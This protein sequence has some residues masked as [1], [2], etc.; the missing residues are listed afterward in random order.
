MNIQV[1]R[2]ALMIISGAAAVFTIGFWIKYRRTKKIKPI[3]KCS[4]VEKHNEAINDAADD[5][6]ALINAKKD[7]LERILPKEWMKIGQIKELFVYPLKSGRGRPLKDSIFTDYG[8]SVTNNGHFPLRD[9]MFLVYKEETGEFKTGRNYPTLVLVTLSAVD[10]TQVKLEAVGMPSL[11]FKVPENIESNLT[12][13]PCS[14]WWG[15]AIECIDCGSEVA[16]WISRFLTGTSN[17]L[18]LGCALG[19]INKSVDDEA[20]E[21]FDSVYTTLRNE[22][23]GL[24]SDLA[25]YMVMSESSVY[26]LNQKLDR[27]GP[28]LQFRPNVVV[29]GPEPFAEDNWEW[30]KI[31]QDVV[32]RNV[33]PYSNFREQRNPNRVQVDGKLPTMGIYCGLYQ[34]GNVK[35]GDDVYVHT[36]RSK[37][38]NSD[39]KFESQRFLRQEAEINGHDSIGNGL[40]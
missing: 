15:K 12:P 11:T 9:R 8:I 7:A 18:R 32:I 17:G 21:K 10:E 20:W 19:K 25:T 36:A 14:L 16:R 39:P 38:K 37:S 35:I 30:I 1:S 33:K 23:T 40:S 27:P 3:E 6:L 28:A 5:T 26:E 24:Y 2:T 22:G 29:S 31:G 13:V 34:A 4:A